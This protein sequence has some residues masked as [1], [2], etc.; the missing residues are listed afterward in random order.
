MIRNK[1]NQYILSLLASDSHG[2]YGCFKS[3]NSLTE[4]LN[5]VD[6]D[7]EQPTTQEEYMAYMHLVVET[8][9]VF[10]KND[11]LVTLA[12]HPGQIF[13]KQ[14]YDPIDRI[15]LMAYDMIQTNDHHASYDNGKIMNFES[16]FYVYQ[17]HIIHY[18]LVEEGTNE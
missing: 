10:H 4:E 14:F 15:H 6:F 8:S 17:V 1:P 7:W 3:N 9:E 13:P 2:Y 5:G 12:L 11:L 18:T 16:V